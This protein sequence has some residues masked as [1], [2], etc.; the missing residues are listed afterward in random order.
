MILAGHA[1]GVLFGAAGAIVGASV[2]GLADVDAVSVSMARLAPGTLSPND[3]TLAILAAVVTNTLSKIG[4][5]AATGRGR[6]AVEITI[7]AL[8]CLAAGAVAAVAAFA[9]FGR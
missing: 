3:A 9:I 4:I 1:L 7:M 5:G 8:L 6:F 2:A